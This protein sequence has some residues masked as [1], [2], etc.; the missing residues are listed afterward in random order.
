M[1]RRFAPLLLGGLAIPLLVLGACEPAIPHPIEGRDDC[2][3]CHGPGGIKP[4]PTFHAQQGYGNADC[5]QCHKPATST[6]R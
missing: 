6:G 5:A 1:G 4:Y 3:S 2:V